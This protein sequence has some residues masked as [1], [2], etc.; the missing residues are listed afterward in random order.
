MPLGNFPC[1]GVRGTAFCE[2][3]PETDG[4]EEGRSL[5]REERHVNEQQRTARE[6]DALEL[7]AEELERLRVLKEHELG[8]R[9]EYDP[10]AGGPYV[11]NVEE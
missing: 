2:L 8:V 4:L 10:D 1:T 9:L 5:H 3:R 7:I 11:P 6:L